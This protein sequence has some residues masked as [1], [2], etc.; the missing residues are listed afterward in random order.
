MLRT[1]TDRRSRSLGCPAMSRQQRLSQR[2]FVFSRDSNSALDPAGHRLIAWITSAGSE[3]FSPGWAS[4]SRAMSPKSL[5]ALLGRRSGVLQ[6]LIFA[7]SNGKRCQPRGMAH[8]L[9]SLALRACMGNPRHPSPQRKQGGTGRSHI[10][11]RTGLGCSSL[12]VP[13]RCCDLHGPVA[14][15][16]SC[17]RRRLDRAF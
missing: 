15:C 9:L 6:A 1:E 16:G 10:P 2:F 7:K 17:R 8:G 11:C 4:I 5:I 3:A 13:V 12:G 14:E